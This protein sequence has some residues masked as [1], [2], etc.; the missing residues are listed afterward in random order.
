MKQKK[1]RGGQI[2]L[3]GGASWSPMYCADVCVTGAPAWH[4]VNLSEPCLLRHPTCLMFINLAKNDA[5][6]GQNTNTLACGPNLCMKRV[7]LFSN[8]KCNFDVAPISQSARYCL[9]PPPLM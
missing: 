7:V 3:R 6:E 9:P 2:F 8:T 1:P 4:T 5:G